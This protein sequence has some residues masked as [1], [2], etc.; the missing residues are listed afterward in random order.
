MPEQWT[1]SLTAK[2]RRFNEGRKG[3]KKLWTPDS[4]VGGEICVK[5]VVYNTKKGSK[6]KEEKK[7]KEKESKRLKKYNNKKKEFCTL[8]HT[9]RAW[10]K[11]LFVFVH[12]QLFPFNTIFQYLFPGFILP[13]SPTLYKFIVRAFWAWVHSYFG[14]KSKPV[15]TI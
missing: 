7:K 15:L 11:I 9:T 10:P 5:T 4:H 3:T 6:E 1:N 13:F 2:S 14:F 12:M 8:D